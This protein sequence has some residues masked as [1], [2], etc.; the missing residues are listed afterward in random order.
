MDGLLD[1]LFPDNDETTL[2][3]DAHVQQTQLSLSPIVNTPGYAYAN[4]SLPPSQLSSP[5]SLNAA[6]QAHQPSPPMESAMEPGTM[7]EYCQ[8]AAAKTAMSPERAIALKSM[9]IKLIRDL[10]DLATSGA[11][12]ESEYKLQKDIILGQM[13]IL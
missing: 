4:V 3:P 1:E 13:S 10:Y 12:T 7:T 11:I 9:Y 6:F 2:D 5:V 8:T